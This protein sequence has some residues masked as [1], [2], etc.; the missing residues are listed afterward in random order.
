ML[1]TKWLIFPFGT[2]TNKFLLV[3]YLLGWSAPTGLKVPVGSPPD[4]FRD[5]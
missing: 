3:S 5:R 4:Q 1:P 2:I